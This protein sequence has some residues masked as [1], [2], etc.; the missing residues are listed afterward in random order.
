MEC[1]MNIKTSPQI[2]E[3]VSAMSKAQG[4]MKPAVMNK[5][6]PHFKNRYADFN[7]CMEACRI[8]LSENGLAVIQ[9]PQTIEGKLTLVTMIAHSSGQWM[10]GEFP[11]I[12]TKQDSQGIGSAMTYAKRYSLS[13]MLGIVADEDQD[14]DGEASMG[15]GQQACKPQAQN[16]IP[17]NSPK[18]NIITINGGQV[19]TLRALE[20]KLTPDLKEKI[21]SWIEKQYEIKD[22]V[23]IPQ[24]I[25]SKIL[26]QLE[27]A[28]KFMESEKS[29]Q[30]EVAHV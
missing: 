5:V 9:T 6:N 30:E 1:P 15:R 3:I 2:N 10:T 16:Q 22:Y 26:G 25:Y 17:S 20:A 29:K 28:V 7:S 19:A 14:D 13:G 12:A 24:D 8:P 11:L 21:N 4:S 18:N 27:N 23:K